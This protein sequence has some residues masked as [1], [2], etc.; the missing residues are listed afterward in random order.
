MNLR[1]KLIRLAYAKPQL[2]G[3]LLPLLKQGSMG[4]TFETEHI[5]VHRYSHSIKVWDL[6]NAGRRGKTVQIFSLYDLDNLRGSWEKAIDAFEDSLRHKTYAQALQAAIQFME[7]ARNDNGRGD[8]DWAPVVKIEQYV[9]KGVKVTP[10][11]M[12]PIRIQGRNIEVKIE[13]LDFSV[14]DLTDKFNE[15]T[16]I[17][18]SR[19]ATSTPLLYAW[20]VQ[21][22]DKIKSMTFGEMRKVMESLGVSYHYYMAVD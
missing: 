7:D 8:V 14:L 12:G 2:R 11:N 20:A 3:H 10:R 4:D 18:G 21:N 17:P 13:H 19:K 9:E 16:M 6:T 1:Q 5:R 15:P 22:Q